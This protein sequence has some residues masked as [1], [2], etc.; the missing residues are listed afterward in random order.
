MTSLSKGS[1]APVVLMAH[2]SLACKQET[3]FVEA[4]K[5][6]L[7]W[8]FDDIGSYESNATKTAGELSPL[9]AAMYVSVLM[10]ITKLH[11]NFLLYPQG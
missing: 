2:L 7:Q 4:L 3:H 1:N 8:H 10:S 5:T 11:L 9:I 6:A